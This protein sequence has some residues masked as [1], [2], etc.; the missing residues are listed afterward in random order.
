MESVPIVL[1]FACAVVYG[2]A[3][4]SGG[5]ASRSTSSMVITLVGQSSS[6]LVA[7]AAVAI[8]GQAP[9]GLADWAWGAGVGIAGA[10]AL[11]AFYRAMAQGA[12]TVVAPITAVVSASLPVAFGLAR[13][14]RPEPLALVGIAIAVAAVLLVSGAIG[15]THVRTPGPVI[16]LAVLAGVGFAL[17]FIG[18]EQTSES[19]GFWPLIA[20]RL[21]SV[22][23]MVVLVR[24]SKVTLPTARHTWILAV[25]SGVLDMSANV[26]YLLAVRRGLLSIVAAVSSLYPVSTVCLAFGLDR[27]RVT[28]W[29]ATG[30]GLAGVA[31]VLVSVA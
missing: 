22:T 19:S 26:L 13:G 24:R 4:Y 14:E 25:T 20:A 23:G 15:V 2:I 18:L 30:M 31:L 12:M 5:R 8:A 17:V 16:G 27:E 28:R 3:D 11:V 1:A 10:V 6:L 29:Q 21:A 9:P 7:F